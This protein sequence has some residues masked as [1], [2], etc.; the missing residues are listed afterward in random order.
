MYI[1]IKENMH[2]TAASKN[3]GGVFPFNVIWQYKYDANQ[4]LFETQLRV[5]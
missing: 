5:K 1:K 2:K 3:E 4:T